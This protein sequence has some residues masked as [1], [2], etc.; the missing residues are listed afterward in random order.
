MT[1]DS[2][3]FMADLGDES[4]TAQILTDIA[5]FIEK[6]I[7]YIGKLFKAFTVKPNYTDG[8]DAE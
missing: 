7:D 1:F 2:E 4:K 8:W 3:K 5:N 6:L